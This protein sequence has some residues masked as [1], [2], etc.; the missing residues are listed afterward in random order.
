MTRVSWFE[1]LRSMGGAD[2][3]EA[4]PGQ[5]GQ[6]ETCKKRKKNALCTSRKRKEKFQNEVETLGHANHRGS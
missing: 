2:K 1:K 5:K 4:T 6:Q 3:A